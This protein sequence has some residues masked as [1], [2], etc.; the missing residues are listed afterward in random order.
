MYMYSAH[1]FDVMH[2]SL[3]LS[4]SLSVSFFLQPNHNHLLLHTADRLYI[5]HTPSLGDGE[6]R[7][8]VDS[9]AGCY[10]NG[11]IGGEA[12]PHW[13]VTQVNL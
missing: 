3:S 1:Q 8:K 4:L 10:G 7:E 11:L 13:R 12:A 6:K 2:L 5:G 9:G